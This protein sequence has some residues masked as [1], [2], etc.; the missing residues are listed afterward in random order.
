MRISVPD[1]AK[2]LL[3]ASP[4]CGN[5]QVGLAVFPVS[6]LPKAMPNGNPALVCSTLIVA[7]M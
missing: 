4:D 1:G 2:D 5:F 7:S 6:G 3:R